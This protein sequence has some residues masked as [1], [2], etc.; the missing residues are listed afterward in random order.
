MSV[1]YNSCSGTPTFNS[2]N[3]GKLYIESFKFIGVLNDDFLTAKT[4][5]QSGTNGVYENHT[6][7]TPIAEQ[8]RGSVVN[9][10]ARSAGTFTVN[11]L[12]GW[13]YWMAWVDWNRDGAFDDATERV[14]ALQGYLTKS[15]TFGFVITNDKPLGDYRIRI[16]TIPSSC[17]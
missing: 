7:L 16:A 11:G 3:T 14:Y 1:V 6:T 12:V 8:V 4:S 15:V 5:T 10:E 17:S 13:G 9:I 2:N